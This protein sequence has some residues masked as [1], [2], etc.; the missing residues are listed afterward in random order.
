MCFAINP[1]A[2]ASALRIH[3]MTDRIRELQLDI[4]NE[5]DIYNT[6]AIIIYNV[7]FVIPLT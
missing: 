6:N 7:L 1:R 5:Y 2:I 4:I 3:Q